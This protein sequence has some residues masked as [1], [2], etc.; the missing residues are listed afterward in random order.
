MSVIGLTG[1]VGSGKSY[2]ASVLKAHFQLHVID[3]DT[4]GHALLMQPIIKAQLAQAFGPSVLQSEGH[5][6]RAALR[7][8]AFH[9]PTALLHLNH[10]MHP[11]LTAEA[12]NQI[13]QTQA[14][15][16]TRLVVG[17]L[18]E[19]LSLASACD[20]IIVVDAEDALIESHIGP[21][22]MFS[23]YQ[24]SREAYLQ[25]GHRL[26]NTFDDTTASRAINLFKG[27]I[28]KI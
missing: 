9:S 17:A 28:H 6:N 3:L 7:E 14:L 15:G 4:I 25:N 1:R 24:K 20:H 22:F 10:I 27:L 5:I 26:A 19:E 23:R 21:K 11:P 16:L 18:L 13:K 8:Q 2:I 12:L